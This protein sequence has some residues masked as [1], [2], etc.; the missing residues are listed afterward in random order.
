ML[1]IIGL[2]HSVTPRYDLIQVKPLIFPKLCIDD[3]P[4]AWAG[5]KE[6]AQANYLHYCPLFA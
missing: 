4:L 1:T 6:R 3:Y 5:S 2:P